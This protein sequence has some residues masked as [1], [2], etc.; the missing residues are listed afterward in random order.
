[1]VYA[2]TSYAPT[3]SLPRDLGQELAERLEGN[4]DQEMFAILAAGL[5]ISKMERSWERGACPFQPTSLQ[6]SGRHEF[7]SGRLQGW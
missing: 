5:P 6:A 4:P 2:L 7:L 3:G 1:M